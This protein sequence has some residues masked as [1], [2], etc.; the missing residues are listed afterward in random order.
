MLRS[1]DLLRTIPERELDAL[2]PRVRRVRYPPNQ[3]IF[4]K[5]D[6]GS[7]VMFVVSGRVKIV[8][9]S[10]SG[11]ELILNI[12]NPGQV[13]GEL[14]LIDGKPRS[15]DAIAAA[16]TELL[17]LSRRDFLDVLSRNLEV[18]LSMMAILCDRIRQ[19]TSFVEDAVLLDGQARLLHRIKA[20]ADQYGSVEPDGV[21]MRIEHQLSQQE[22]GERVGLTRVSINRM[23]SAWRDRGLIEDGRGYIV[24]RDMAR[25]EEAVEQR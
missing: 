14:A 3:I 18:S 10:P 22:L 1:S 4:Q 19:A 5:N 9:V 21:A 11:S 24:V 17:T 15:A 12:M 7:S 20:M 23:L 16:E 8:S 6:E 25:L 2:T 13:F